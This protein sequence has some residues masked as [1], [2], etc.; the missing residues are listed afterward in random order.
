MPEFVTGRERTNSPSVLVFLCSASDSI[1]PMRMWFW[2]AP[3]L[4][5]VPPSASH[6]ARLA[7]GGSWIRTRGEPTAVVIDDE[8]SPDSPGGSR[9]R[10]VG[11]SRKIRRF[12][13]ERMQPKK[14]GLEPSHHL[15]GTDISNR[16][17]SSRES[18]GNS[19]NRATQ[20]ALVRYYSPMG[21]SWQATAYRKGLTG[22]IPGCFTVFY[23]VKRA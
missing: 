1:E 19:G 17:S 15:S 4:L 7:A 23:N 6:F 20:M 22:I 3:L 10:N 11:R 13:C 21:E 18:A 2:G 5:R 8:S 14:G 12:V 9:I 16:S